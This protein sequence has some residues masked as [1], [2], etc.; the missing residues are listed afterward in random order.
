M[1]LL[2]EDRLLPSDPGTRAVGRRLYN[3]IRNLPIVS[4]HGHADPRW[5]AEDEPFPN[6][7]QLFVTPDHYISRMLY[8]QGVPLEDLYG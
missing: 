8:S 3:G 6:P 1:V 4:P 5:F 2:Q 7:A